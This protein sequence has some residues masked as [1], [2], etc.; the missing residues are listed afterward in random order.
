MARS[1]ATVCLSGVLPDKLDSATRAGFEAVEL[2]ENDLLAHD[3]TPAEVRRM[4]DDLGLQIAL[5]QPFRDFEAMPEPQRSRNLDRAERKF[6]IMQALGC[7]QILVCSNV[8]EA[9]SEDPDRAAADLRAMAER[10]AARG[11]RVGYEAL[12][13]GRHVNRWRQ[14]WDI[15]Q[16]ADHPALGLIVDSFHTLCVGDDPSG[17]A[18]L[19]GEKIFFVQL[20]DGP[21]LSMDVLSWSRHFRNF[22]GQ[23]ELD[24][25]GFLRAVLASGYAGPLSLEV[26]NDGFRAAPPTHTARD[27]LRSLVLVEAEARPR[28]PAAALPPVQEPRGIEFLEFAVDAETA[29]S[30]EAYISSF[31][32]RRTGRH[33]SK[34]VNLWS[35][36]KARL[37]VN[38]EPDGAAAG[39]FALHGPSVCAMALRVPDGDAV[40]RRANALHLSTW[41]ER[42]GEDE[43]NIQ[44]VRTPDGSLVLLVDDG[45]WERDFVSVGDGAGALEP[46]TGIDHVALS[47]PAWQVDAAVLFWRGLFGLRALAPVDL[48]DPRGLVRSR[49]LVTQGGGL[50]LPL[51]ASDWQGTATGRFLHASSGGG[52][53]HIAF[54]ATDAAAATV[55]LSLLDLP[56]NYYD[57][58]EARFGL[59]GATL[60]PLRHGRLLYDRDAAQGEFI[61]AYGPLYAHR[62]FFEVVERRQGYAGFGEAN[63]AVRLAAQAR[64]E[65]HASP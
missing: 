20:A 15:V 9:A 59:D 19:P 28:T 43:E 50:R 37:V 13:W 51:N 53:H 48:P 38:A 44:G 46:F 52:V 21:K 8:Q 26:F 16:R 42:H 64:H 27:G 60:D 23:G 24:V 63:A 14:A 39:H 17:L 12:A 30:V 5:Y 18:E 10:A 29:G 7:D 54:A 35:R 45:D 62:F 55:G 25:A 49:A 2:F 6:D 65:L 4:A 32:F 33:R 47:L 31:G 40:V 41:R 1:I 11:L 36:G 61:H 34:A 3:G 22:P 57:D 58:L 56:A